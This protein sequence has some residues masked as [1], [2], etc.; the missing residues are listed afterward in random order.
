MTNDKNT[1]KNLNL[2]EL[3]DVTGG[4]GSLDMHDTASGTE[5]GGYKKQMPCDS[6]EQPTEHTW[7]PAASAWI[8]STC[9]AP[10]SDWSRGR[11]PN[12]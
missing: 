1:E 3:T 11:Y 4:A 7:D 12:G 9:S 6:C 5:T 8:C 10:T 2:E